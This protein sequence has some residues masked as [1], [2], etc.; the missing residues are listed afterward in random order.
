MVNGTYCLHKLG[1]NR[2]RPGFANRPL[3]IASP[4]SLSHDKTNKN[5]SVSSKEPITTDT[6][7]IQI[8]D[9]IHTTYDNIQTKPV[10][11]PHTPN[12]LDKTF[13]VDD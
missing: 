8:N 2:E 12:M 13:T 6:Y 1:K 10:S 7:H 11:K 3:N 9:V 4:T 5:I